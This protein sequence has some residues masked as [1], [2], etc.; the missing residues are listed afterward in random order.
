MPKHVFSFGPQGVEG[1]PSDKGR[2]GGKGAGLAAMTKLGVPVPSG[3]T[4]SAELCEIR[5]RTG[6]NPPELREQV[7][8]ALRKVESAIGTKFGDRDNP[9]LVSVR[10]GAAISMPGMMDT[11][12]N[13]GLTRPSVEGLAR[14]T[15]NPRFAWDSYRRLL[16]MY[17]SVV[18]RVDHHAFEEV[19]ASARKAAGVKEDSQLSAEQLQKVVDGY[20]L[21]I[22]RG[23]DEFPDDARSQLDGAIEAVFKSW[24]NERAITYRKINKIT[25]LLGTAVTVQAMVFGN[26]GERSATGVCFT[27]DPATGE[28]RFFGEWLRN[29]QGEDVVAGIRTPRP[30]SEM[31]RDLPEVY[32]QLV[33]TKDR[34]EAHFRDLLDLEFTVQEGTLYMLQTR[35]GKRA[36]LGAVRIAV[37]MVEEKRLTPAEAVKRVEPE[38]VEQLLFPVL[39]PSAKRAAVAGKRLLATGLGV[40]PGAA[41]GRPVFTAAEAEAAA[42][43]GEKVVLV[44]KET[45]PEDIGGMNA[46][47]GILTTVGGRT[48]HAAVV[49]RGLGKCCVVGCGTLEVDPGRRL[50]RG[51]GVTVAGGEPISLDGFTGEVFSGTLATRESEVIATVVGGAAAAKGGT[52][53]LYQRLM[54]F[55]DGSRK[56]GVRAN[57]DTPLDA[58]VARKLGAEGIGLCRTEHMFFAPEERIHAMRE[59]ILARKAGGA[60]RALAKLLP[61]QREDFHAIFRAMEGFPVTIRLLDPPLHEFLPFDTPSQERVAGDMGIPVA[62]IAHT[63]E[64]LREANPMLG[65]RG[66]R[67][68]VTM[69]EIY[70]MQTRAVLEAAAAVA[71]EGGRVHPEIM[72]PLV[73]EARELKYLRDRVARIVAEVQAATKTKLPLLIGTMVEVPRAAVTAGRIAEV[74]DFFSF[75][76]NDLTQ[77]TFGISRDD[78]G[79][80]IGAYLEKEIYPQDPFR[81]L[82]VEGVGQLMR[83]ATVEGRKTKPGLQVGICGEV[84]GDPASIGFCHALGLDYVS[85]SP[86]RVPVARLAAARAALAA[87]K[88]SGTGG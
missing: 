74:A 21:A 70:E 47:A 57:A 67:V 48:S 35:S 13:L 29:A 7:D 83:W 51:N 86:Y 52:A 8:E 11:I 31:E 30:I 76:T 39:D 10:S 18:L 45:T 68:G 23:G 38:H 62:E 40:G 5:K 14:R 4:I 75:G 63:V 15:K 43:A 65:H 55:A 9:L 27:R 50:V 88:H 81:T 24:D 3:F 66:C 25:G 1:D 6:T 33:A 34:L 44:R 2:L 64:V 72:I 71:R 84:G 60:E 20:V 42:K 82:D 73:G 36:G 17:G 54:G 49:A 12:L 46:A 32:A 26:M 77:T 28:N 41:S 78:V 22:K 56:L 53:D 80:F 85:C 37:E 79:K 19:L 69:P 58:T 87:E 61:M 59:V 16:Q